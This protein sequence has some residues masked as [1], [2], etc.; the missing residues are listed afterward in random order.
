MKIQIN[1]D[2]CELIEGGTIE[3]SFIRLGIP[4]EAVLVE[5][6]GLA[7]HR[8]EWRERLVRE[9]DVIEV[10]RIVAGG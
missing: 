2:S 5:H 7:L 10:I 6:N 3:E 1:G 8:S 9:G 4:L